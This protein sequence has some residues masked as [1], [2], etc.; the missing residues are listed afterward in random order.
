[1]PALKLIIMRH[2]ESPQGTPDHDRTLSLRGE[3]DSTS[4]GEQIKALGW[5]PDLMLCSTATRAQKTCSSAS[6]VFDPEPPLALIPSFYNAQIGII[7]AHLSFITNATTVMLIGHNPMWSKM[8]SVLSDTQIA[9]STA[10]AALLT[11]EAP[12]W[13]EGIEALGSWKLEH[14]IQPRS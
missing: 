8:S 2:G 14:L 11:I 10:N 6:F 9:L 12:S 1:M 13:K 4:T 3:W 7:Q 5:A